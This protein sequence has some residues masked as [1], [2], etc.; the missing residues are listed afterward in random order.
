MRPPNA[1]HRVAVRRLGSVGLAGLLLGAVAAPVLAHEQRDVSGYS[2]EVG[3][4]GEPVFVGQR[5][6]LEFQVTK[7]DKPIS[8]L[9]KT[10]KAE[11]IYGDATQ[12]LPLTERAEDPGWYESVFIPTS[13]GKYTFHIAGDID[14]T[15][16]DE[17]FTSGPTGFDEVQ[18]A[19]AGQFPSTLPTVTELSAEAKKGADAAS[20]VPIALALGAGGLIVGLLGLGIGLAGRRP[21]PV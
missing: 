8:G 1:F 7:D 11:V 9:D 14:G 17:S 3:L 2:F 10:L 12:D 15:A 13:A 16:I 4:I 5:S 6:G 19:T 21:P 20:L 18:E